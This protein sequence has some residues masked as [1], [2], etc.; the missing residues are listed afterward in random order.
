M[1]E[2]DGSD[3]DNHILAPP[4]KPLPGD[5]CGNGCT[6]CVLDVYQKELELWQSL[7]RL[8]PQERA[9]WRSAEL[10]KSKASKKG[11]GEAALHPGSYRAFRIVKM[12]RVTEC[13]YKYTFGLQPNEYLGLGTGQHAMVRVWDKEGAA[14]SRPYTP[15]SP[16]TQLG[17]FEVLIKVRCDLNMQRG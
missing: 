17:S 1:S 13:V 10:Q 3:E 11:K 7:C 16:L 9:E 12:E 4:V 6:P 14:I 2:A 5:C 8:S 15:I